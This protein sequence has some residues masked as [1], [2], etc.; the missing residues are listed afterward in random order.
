MRSL[1]YALDQAEKDLTAVLTAE[2]A[3]RYRLD[4][5]RDLPP[6]ALEVDVW[7]LQVGDLPVAELLSRLVLQAGCDSGPRFLHEW[8][9]LGLI[10]TDGLRSNLLSVWTMA[11]Y[12]EKLGQ[13]TW[14]DMFDSAGYVS[15]GP[16]RPDEDITIYRGAPEW[17]RRRMSW[18]TEPSIA[19]KFARK[20]TRQPG[21]V[22]RATVPPH[23]VLAQIVEGRHEAEVVVNPKC[24]RGS[25]SPT[26]L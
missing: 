5:D 2:R 10:D 1:P 24:L 6:V 16:S 25:A 8:W 21:E 13:R 14:L 12:P 20:K 9:T 18:T 23:A 15:D 4:F 26:P 3:E 11:E 22:W 19:T 17:G 7:L